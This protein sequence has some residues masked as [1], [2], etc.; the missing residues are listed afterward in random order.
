[1]LQ[2]EL[3]IERA[4][5]VGISM[6][7][8][9]A[10]CIALSHP[11]RVKALI[12]I[13]ST[14]EASS[15]DASAA[16]AKVRDIWVSTRSPSEEIMDISI[17]GWGGNPDVKGPRAMS[18]KQHWVKRHSG[19]EN[20]DSILDSVCHRENLLHRLHKIIVPVML[21]H[22]EKDETWKLEGMLR[23][24]DVLV[25]AKVEIFVVKDS[26]H[27]VIHMRESED[28]SEAMADFIIQVLQQ[29]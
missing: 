17:R 11:S 18:V 13:A 24:R 28:V 4:I 12:S 16:I 21:I 1:M 19:A 8:S 5:L 27:L 29:N 9:I 14:G 26:G 7:A 20:V 6:G 23:I 25:N 3:K 2:D 22:G 10:F 15:P